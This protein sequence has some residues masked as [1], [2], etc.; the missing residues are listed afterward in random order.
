[1]VRSTAYKMGPEPAPAPI[2]A[3]ALVDSG[4]EDAF[5][6]SS[7]GVDTPPQQ[8]ARSAPAHAAAAGT[9]SGSPPGSG[10]SSGGSS[11]GGG[12]GSGIP[13]ALRRGRCDGGGDET[14][15]LPSVG[16]PRRGP[17]ESGLRAPRSRAILLP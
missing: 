14:S 8:R 11:S 9:P 17:G 5:S 2:S 15:A 13:I 1:M 6:P 3:G 12:G 10:S 4:V 7:R 16:S